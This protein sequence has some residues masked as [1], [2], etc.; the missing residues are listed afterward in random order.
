MR[1]KRSKLIYHNNIDKKYDKITN[2]I[3]MSKLF[4]IFSKKYHT[5]KR[6]RMSERVILMI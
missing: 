4:Y 3:Y 5:S 2:N 1:I 6:E